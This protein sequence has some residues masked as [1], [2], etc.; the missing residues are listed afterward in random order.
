MTPYA[1]LMID[2]TTR[3]YDTVEEAVA[4]AKRVPGIL[5]HNENILIYWVK[6]GTMGNVARYEDGEWHWFPRY[7]HLVDTQ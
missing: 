6:D 2:F 1:K 7:Q 3:S 4:V 5:P